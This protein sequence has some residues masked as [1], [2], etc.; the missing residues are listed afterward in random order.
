MSLEKSVGPGMAEDNQVLLVQSGPRLRTM[1][2]EFQRGSLGSP[3][4]GW[5]PC[6]DLSGWQSASSASVSS[7]HASSLTLT[8]PA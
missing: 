2:W 1:V 8:P 3:A 5:A 7:P 6:R 4:L